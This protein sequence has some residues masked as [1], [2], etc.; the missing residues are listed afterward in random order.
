[1]SSRPL[2]PPKKHTIDPDRVKKSH[3]CHSWASHSLNLIGCGTLTVLLLLI[4]SFRFVDPK[5]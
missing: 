5:S 3:V 2:L 4:A 1:M